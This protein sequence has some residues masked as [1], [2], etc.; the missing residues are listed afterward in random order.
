MQNTKRKITTK[1]KY[2]KKEFKKCTT[3]KLLINETKKKVTRVFFN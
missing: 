2:K 1:Q 3:K